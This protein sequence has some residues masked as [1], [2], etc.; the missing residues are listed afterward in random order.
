M[1]SRETRKIDVEAASAGASR[2]SD[3]RIREGKNKFPLDTTRSKWTGE[4]VSVEKGV[5][6]RLAGLSS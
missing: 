1:Y 4:V 6:S 2:N 5:V 3:F